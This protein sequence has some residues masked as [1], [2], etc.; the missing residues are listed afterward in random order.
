MSAAFSHYFWSKATLF[1]SFASESYWID[2]GTPE[3]YMMV[4]NDLLL[5]N[6]ATDFPGSKH[7][8]YVWVEEGCNINPKAKI[9][10]PVVIGRN[11]VIE[12]KAHIKGPTVIGPDCCIG[13]DSL[14]ERS[15]VWHNV[16][17][18]KG[19]KIQQCIIADAVSIGEGCDIERGCI[20][21]NSVS[22]Q[23]NVKLPPDTKVMPGE[24]V[25]AP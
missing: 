2:I 3:K 25:S 22:I 21:G 11:C 5:G 4:N 14:V 20:I 6:I 8:T 12:A 24:K 15:I 1:Y 10:G 9:D 7:D 17:I 18:G 16:K 19:A 13:A 23:P